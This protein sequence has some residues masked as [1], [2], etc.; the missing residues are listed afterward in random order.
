[1]I[2]I[3]LLVAGCGFYDGTEAAEAVLAALSL[4]RAGARPVPIAPDALQLH[5]VDH[6]TGSESDEPARG[7]LRE[8]ARIVR[9]RIRS[10]EEVVPA[11]LMGLIIP[12]GHGAVKNLMTG[13]ASLSEP[14]RVIPA[15]GAVLEHLS[16]RKAPIG[17]ISLGRT[18]VQTFL[19]EPLSGD[20]MRL[21]ASEIEVDESRRHVFTPG[22]LTGASLVE[23]AGGIDRMVQTV[24]KMA[25]PGLNVLH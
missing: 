18:V 17:S 7:I 2:R 5:T 11:E 9:G 6:L 3:G 4:E 21:A 1:M 8:S 12:G 25:A 15:V 20:D 14:R 19:G 22:F 24:L 10:L 23:V 13:F 16:E